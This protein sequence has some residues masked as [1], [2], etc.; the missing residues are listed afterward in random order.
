MEIFLFRSQAAP[1]VPLRLI[2][3]QDH[4]CPLSKG[5]VNLSQTFS[6]VLM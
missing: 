1:D 2:K 6:Y 4:P 3:V 5:W